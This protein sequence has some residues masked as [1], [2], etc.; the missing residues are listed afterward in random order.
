MYVIANEKLG[1]VSGGLLI[2]MVDKTQEQQDR[3]AAQIEADVRAELIRAAQ[4][5][6]QKSWACR[7]A[8]SNETIER[9]VGGAY[10]RA[11]IKAKRKVKSQQPDGSEIEIEE[12]YEE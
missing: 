4:E 6:C 3:E 7:N 1:F 12:E 11:V 8:V 5:E 9:T 2:E 10:D